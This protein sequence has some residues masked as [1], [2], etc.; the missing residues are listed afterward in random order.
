MTKFPFCIIINQTGMKE[1]GTAVK[2]IRLLDI[3]KQAEVSQA[4]VTRVIRNN[5]YVSQEKR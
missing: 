3:A 1:A 5:G 4:T 2:G